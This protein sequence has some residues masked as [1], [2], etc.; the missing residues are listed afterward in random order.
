M[1][2]NKKD[3]LQSSKYRNIRVFPGCPVVKTLH[4]HCWGGAGSI[5]GQGTKILHG[6]KT[7]K[8]KQ[9]QQNEQTKTE[10][11][12]FSGGPMAKTLCSQCRG[13]GCNAWSGNYIP[14]APTKATQHVGS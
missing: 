8:K 12:D 3:I 1:T 6:Q 7:N 11:R 14:H 13:P 5:P 4:F 9:Q 10:L 2:Q